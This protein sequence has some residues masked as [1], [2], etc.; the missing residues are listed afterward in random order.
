MLRKI[1]LIFRLAGQDLRANAA[2]HL[3]ATAIISVAFLAA[4]IFLLVAVNLRALTRQWE[5]KIQMTVYLQ[6]E[7]SPAE[8]QA[9]LA[10][11]KARPEVAA[12]EYVSK[13][14]A[15]TE[16]RAALGPDA[17]LLSGLAENPLPPSLVIHLAAPARELSQVQILAAELISWPAVEEVDFGEAWLSA[18]SSALRLLEVGMIALGGLIALAVIFIISN[19]IRL[20]I[21]SRKDE[22]GIMKLVGADNLLLRLPFVL[23]GIAQGLLAAAGG[24]IGLRVLF[25]AALRGW[26]ATGLFAGFS[27]VFLPFSLICAIIFAG[28]VFGAAGSMTRFSTFLRE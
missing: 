16:F 5:K 12:V 9:M 13:E 3:V 6:K 21:Y 26:S 1:G 14:Q 11:L 17:D 25:W 20:T 4:G 27:P 23:E 15:W 18:F 10:D 19:T 28:A 24:A 8:R 22:I 2:I 7:L